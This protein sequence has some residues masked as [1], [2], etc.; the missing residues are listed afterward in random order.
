AHE[1]HKMLYEALEKSM[2]RDHTDQLL[3]DLAEARRKKKK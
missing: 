3:T 1:D 2:V